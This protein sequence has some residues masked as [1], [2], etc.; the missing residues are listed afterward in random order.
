MSQQ[1]TL[2]KEVCVFIRVSSSE[3]PSVMHHLM[4]VIHIFIGTLT[5]NTEDIFFIL[6]RK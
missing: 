4:H 6:P 3:P 2:L 1:N 5:F